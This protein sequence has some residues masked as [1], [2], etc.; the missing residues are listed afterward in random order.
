MMFLPFL[1][2]AAMFILLPLSGR[3]E[4]KRHASMIAGL[5]KHD[6]VRTN[7]GI[8]GTVMDVKDS[9]ITLKV[10]DTSNTRITFDKAAIQAVLKH[11]KGTTTEPAETEEAA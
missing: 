1:L 2:I 7:G 10:D 11:A 8:I 9:Q 4:R 5:N 3:K 6:Q